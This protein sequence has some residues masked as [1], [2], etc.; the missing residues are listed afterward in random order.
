MRVCGMCWAPE[1]RHNALGANH[2]FMAAQL[3]VYR[4]GINANELGNDYDIHIE[5]NLTPEFISPE[6]VKV[7]LPPGPS[8]D[9]VALIVAISR[10]M[11]E[12]WGTV[13]RK[14]DDTLV[15]VGSG[16]T[17]TDVRRELSAAIAR[18]LETGV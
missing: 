10:I 18:A 7:L 17:T 5:L 2:E 6:R 4:S 12:P 11:A 1:N 15:I 14:E 8:A 3:R 13:S 16:L 9:T